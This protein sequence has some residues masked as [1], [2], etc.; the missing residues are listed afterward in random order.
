MTHY[1]Y[2]P[3]YQK[4]VTDSV[5][6][7]VQQWIQR[8]AKVNNNVTVLYRGQD[9]STLPSNSK[10]FLLMLGQPG[11]A[12]KL[13]NIKNLDSD[14]I[15]FHNSLNAPLRLSLGKL[16]ILLPDF[17]DN[18][19][20]DGLFAGYTNKK[21]HLILS[22]SKTVTQCKIL[23][24][25]F[26]NAIKKHSGFSENSIR[27]DF[28]TEKAQPNNKRIFNHHPLME[29]QSTYS[30]SE[31]QPKLSQKQVEAAL[32]EYTSYKSSR[33]CGMSGFLSL[34]GFFSSNE[35]KET[36]NRLNSA[37][38][39][40]QRFFLAKQFLVNHS[41]KYLAECLSP[42]IGESLKNDELYWASVESAS[43]QKLAS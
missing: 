29:K 17:A 5:A 2:V 18:L 21:L 42:L 37:K 30:N 43:V 11:K 38:S 33:L 25:S 19:V 4:D 12:S 36:I 14:V 27:I 9:L 41:E 34:N 35:S 15:R 23:A 24:E 8:E 20:K 26:N 10:I 3:F 22:F 28:F 16:S 13:A 6:G 40:E 7:F 31:C 1:V 32:R 39:D